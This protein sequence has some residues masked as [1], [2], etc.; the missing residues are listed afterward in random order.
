MLSMDPELGQEVPVASIDKELR[1]LWEADEVHTNASLI[2]LVTCSEQAGSLRQ[3]SAII[4]ELTREHAC[5]AI[6]VEFDRTVEVPSIRAWVTAHCHLAEGKKSVCCEQI[7]FAFTGRVT[8]RFR[9]TV[10]GHLNSDLPLVFWWQ[11]ELSDVFRERLS[12][13]IDRLVIDSSSWA[14][15]AANFVKLNDA[16]ASST[17]DLVVQDLAWTRTWQYR[18]SLAGIFDEPVALSALPAIEK[19]RIVHHPKHR[20]SALQLLAWISVQAGW[21]SGLDLAAVRAGQ[22]ETF[23]MESKAGVQIMATLEADPAAA[24]LG[25][26]EITAPNVVIRLSRAVGSAHLVRELITNGTAQTS[27]A[28]ADPDDDA[29]LVGA[30]LAR[31]GKNTLYR[32]VLPRFLELLAY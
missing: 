11:G 14:D 13:V 25:L 31:G 29:G 8:G 24:P 6:L 3:N 21:R 17:L 5:R 23:P 30:Q 27:L 9:N 2:N 19:V 28:P 1:K 10:F 15:P 16:V 4:R 32:K 18:L 20:S 7:A 26:L 12:S 22:V